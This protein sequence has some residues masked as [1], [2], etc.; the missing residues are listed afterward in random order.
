MNEKNIAVGFWMRLLSDSLDAIFLAAFGFVLSLPL[1]GIFY[2]MGENGLWLGL[3]ITFLY[4]GILQSGIGFGQS[5]AKRLLKIQVLRLDGSFLNLPQSFLRYSVIALIFYNQWIGT[6]LLSLF[7]ALNNSIFQTV[8]LIVILFLLTGTI[9]LVAFHPLK[10]GLH[11]MLVG[12]IVVR[13][14]M[15]DSG[16]INELRDPS[17]ETK[18]FVICGVLLLLLIGGIYFVFQK[19]TPMQPLLA[20]LRSQKQEIE[21]NTQFTDVSPNFNWQSFQQADGTTKKTSGVNI[22]AFLEK[23]KFDNEKM[24]LA[25]VQKAVDIVINSYSKLSE[26]DYINVQV[27]TGYNIGIWSL[28]FKYNY[29][30]TTDGKPYQKNKK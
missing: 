22:F 29:P 13:K 25:E 6:G 14:D 16:K 2:K 15:Y 21:K 24:Q 30:Y 20:E 18:A 4:T 10:R 7:P 17:K 12:S 8:Y 19:T 26:C 28:Y 3:V 1:G 23:S 9:I 27:R 11:D 5:L